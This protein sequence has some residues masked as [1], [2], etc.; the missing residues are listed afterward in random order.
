M[1][2]RRS[3][4]S[5]VISTGPTL[6][7]RSPQIFELAQ[8]TISRVA[9]LW[10][11]DVIALTLCIIAAWGSYDLSRRIDPVVFEIGTLNV[12]FDGDIP[13]IFTDMNYRDS[14]LYTT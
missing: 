4:G 3:N 7:A 1:A 14:E 9:T 13:R 6:P 8:A 5:D 12:W 2:P 10:R 11:D